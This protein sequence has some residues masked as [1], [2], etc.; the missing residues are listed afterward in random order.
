[1]SLS[2]FEVCSIYTTN[3]ILRKV[4]VIDR[5][6]LT[7]YVETSYQGRML[8]KRSY[9]LALILLSVSITLLTTLTVDAYEILN[10]YVAYSLYLMPSECSGQEYYEKGNLVVHGSYISLNGREFIPFTRSLEYALKEVIGPSFNFKDEI[11]SLRRP[12]SDLHVLRVNIYKID[13]ELTKK[14][15]YLCVNEDTLWK[16]HRLLLKVPI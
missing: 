6:S 7:I 2:N 3:Y 10:I 4:L 15:M 5:K 1:M 8:I 11:I 13:S 14:L 12:I 9:L 16:I